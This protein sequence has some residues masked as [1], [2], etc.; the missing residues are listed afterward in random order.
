[1]NFTAEQIAEATGGTVVRDA[2][3][4]PIGTDTRTLSGGEWFVA[5][6]G[7]RY[8]A[9]DHLDAASSALGVVVDRDVDFDGGVVRVDD[10][11]QALQDLG[12]AAR[13]RLQTPVVGLT[14][15]AGK[16][17]T[18]ALIA[19]A[20]SPMGR[21]HQT[22]G[23]LNNHF[24]VP[25]TLVATPANTAVSVVEMGTSGPGEIALLA[26]IGTPDVRLIVNIGASHLEEL[27]GL[28]GVAVEK[29]A[30]FRSAR[31]GDVCCI[32]T[33]DPRLVDMA[34][35]DGVRVVRFGWGESVDVQLVDAEIDPGRLHTLARIRV[36]DVFVDC[37]LPAPGVHL[38]HNATAALAVAHALGVD[39]R[40]AAAALA[41]YA[42]VGMRLAV[43]P[44]GNGVTAFNDAYNANPTSMQASLDMFA[45]L[46]G[47]KAVVL[48]DMLELGAEEARFHDEVA[49]RAVRLGFERILLVGPRMSAALP[50]G[51]AGRIDRAVNGDLLVPDLASW[52][53]P[54]DLVLFKGSRGARVERILQR[55]EEALTAPSEDT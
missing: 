6:V 11:T 43:Q 28:D 51:D 12:R 42:P 49:E 22:V 10:T 46:P 21:V 20:L 17:T 53:R 35:P 26:D 15:S 13:A 54:G 23:N 19:L 14:G 16:T 1:M 48:G 52:L 45:S 18:R 4:G 39:P 40:E 3:S 24:G 5:I 36:G 29:G 27:G 31:P 8:D 7:E 25:L 55:L 30:L 34:V 32:N 9:H 2:G 33:D 41:D 44:L 37:D 50:D 38:A 47:R